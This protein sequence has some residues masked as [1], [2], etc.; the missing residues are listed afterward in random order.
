MQEVGINIDNGRSF[1]GHNKSFI[2]S[3]LTNINAL[4]AISLTRFKKR[5]GISNSNNHSF[6][7]F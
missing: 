7:G 3:E 1:V 5:S 4:D 2:A 6:L